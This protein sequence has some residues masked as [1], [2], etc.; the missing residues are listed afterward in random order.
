MPLPTPDLSFLSQFLDDINRIF[1]LTLLEV[2]LA[3]ITG[4]VIYAGLTFLMSHDI[5]RGRPQQFLV[6]T[7]LG[8]PRFVGGLLSSHV[9]RL[10]LYVL[11][12]DFVGMGVHNRALLRVV[13]MTELER[14]IREL[15]DKILSLPKTDDL[16]ALKAERVTTLREQA[17]FNGDMAAA[18]DKSKTDHQRAHREFIKVI[19]S[20]TK[21]DDVVSFLEHKF[22][23]RRLDDAISSLPKKD[24]VVSTA[25]HQ[26]AIQQLS[27][28]IDALP[29]QIDVLRILDQSRVIQDLKHSIDSIQGV[30]STIGTTFVRV[31]ENNISLHDIKAAFTT[32]QQRIYANQ[33]KN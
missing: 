15:N 6:S 30:I 26:Q 9:R 5:A 24:D 3:L 7:L 16:L 20:L 22:A 8:P 29:D 18:L 11:Q 21:K 31:E 28:S 14:A 23:L 2:F 32:V 12:D 13:N 17:T 1:E 4:L 25:E 33:Q 19:A 27:D 10:L